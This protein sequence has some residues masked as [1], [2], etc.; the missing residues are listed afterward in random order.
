MFS[1]IKA[2]IKSFPMNPPVK[3]EWENNA[4]HMYTCNSYL[5]C[6]ICFYKTNKESEFFS[7]IYSK[8]DENK[9]RE[10]YK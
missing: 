2:S 4:I 3:G 10:E 8:R 6:V 7:E 5:L 1:K 9:W